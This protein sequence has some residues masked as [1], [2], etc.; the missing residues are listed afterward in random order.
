M[1]G[2][3]Q[4]GLHRQDYLSGLGVERPGLE[5]MTV[6]FDR[7]GQGLVEEFQRPGIGPFQLGN[8]V[9]GDIA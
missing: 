9:D 8:A 4:I 2:A 6:R 1:A 3:Q 5:P 7:F